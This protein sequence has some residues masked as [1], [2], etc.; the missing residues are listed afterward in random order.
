MPN[1]LVFFVFNEEK[2]S[3]VIFDKEMEGKI[4][5]ERAKRIIERKNVEIGG[6]NYFPV[7]HFSISDRFCRVEYVPERV[8]W[9]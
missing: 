7:N 8:L 2:E 1:E 3:Y 5:E 4:C 9:P 6:V